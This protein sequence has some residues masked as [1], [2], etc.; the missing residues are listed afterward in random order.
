MRT[1]LVPGRFLS[2]RSQVRVLPGAPAQPR[3]DQIPHLAG[4]TQQI[5]SSAVRELAA[6][7][8]ADVRDLAAGDV[9]RRDVEAFV[10]TDSTWSSPA[11]VSADFRALPQF[12]KWLV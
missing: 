8:A 10:G 2:G 5:Y 12:F 7:L 3:A 4:S 1:R 11:T 6:F 9:H